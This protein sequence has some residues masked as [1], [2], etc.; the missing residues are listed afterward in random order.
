MGKSGSKLKIKCIKL[1]FHIIITKIFDKQ[2]KE[3]YFTHLTKII[4]LQ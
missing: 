2:Y 3:V 4:A 1:I